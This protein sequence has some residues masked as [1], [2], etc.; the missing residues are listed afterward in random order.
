[1]ITLGNA[2]EM[3]PFS[4][5]SPEVRAESARRAEEAEKEERRRNQ[6]AKLRTA[7]VPPEFKCADLATCDPS[8]AE[9]V[10]RVREGSTRNLILQGKP[11]V[12]KTYTAV[13]ALISLLPDVTGRFVRETDIVRRLRDVMN[14]RDSESAVIET[15]SSPKVL[16]LD[17]FGKV[18]HRDWSLPAMWEIIDNRYSWHRPTIFTMQGDSALLTARLS[19]ETDQGYTAGSI[20]DRM[21]DSDVVTL[22]G[23]SRRGHRA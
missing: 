5:P 1:M 20:V 3:C 10:K 21:R 18:Q 22:Q 13:A 17:D 16:V 6:V 4:I 7:H 2:L 23:S 19:T 14:G 9:W 15:Y 8:I 11:G 12:G